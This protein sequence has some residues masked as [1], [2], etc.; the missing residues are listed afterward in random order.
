MGGSSPEPM[1]SLKREPTGLGVTPAGSL[2][3]SLAMLCVS[4]SLDTLGV[5][6]G[7]ISLRYSLSQS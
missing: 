6:G 3:N 7:C 2:V 4:V 5:Q 1:T